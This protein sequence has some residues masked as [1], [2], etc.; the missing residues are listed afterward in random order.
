MHPR[1]TGPIFLPEDGSAQVLLTFPE[2]QGREAGLTG[3]T[4]QAPHVEPGAAAMGQTQ[5]VSTHFLAVYLLRQPGVLVPSGG[6]S[7]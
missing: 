1:S 4:V 5:S 2:G 7:E 6:L 3:P